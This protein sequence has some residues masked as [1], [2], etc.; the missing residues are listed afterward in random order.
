MTMSAVSV[1]PI[2]YS[3]RRC[4]YAMRARMALAVAAVVYVTREVSLQA[5]PAAMLEASPKATVPVLVLPNG[6]VIDES[7]DIMRW[8]LE[9][10]DPNRWLA[11][12]AT[13]DGEMRE[14][15][16]V[17]DGPFKFHLDRMKYAARYPGSDPALHRADALKLLRLL[18]QRLCRH[19]YLCGAAPLLADVAIF[20]FVRQFAHADVAAFASEQLPALQAWLVQWESSAL[21]VAAMSKH[22]VWLANSD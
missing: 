5:K 2:L 19:A 13:K 7:L 14:L 12:D 4:P 8:A 22:P 21:F 6:R 3:F 18:E 16:E 17:N 10:N 11:P 20:P 1:Q 15:I 9:Q